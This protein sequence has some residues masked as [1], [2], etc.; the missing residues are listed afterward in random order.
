M[1]VIYNVV[2]LQILQTREIYKLFFSV[3]DKN[4]FWKIL[5]VRIIKDCMEIT[6]LTHCNVYQVLYH[7]S[8]LFPYYLQSCLKMENN[9]ATIELETEPPKA[10]TTNLPDDEAQNPVD[11]YEYQTI[12]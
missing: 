10:D 2:F 9:Q 8:Y 5:Y 4:C 12:H 3:V 7:L 6:N 11:G 1:E